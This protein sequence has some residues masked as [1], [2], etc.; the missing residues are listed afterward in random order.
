[1]LSL[2]CFFLC[3]D[4]GRRAQARLPDRRQRPAEDRPRARAPARPFRPRRGRDPQRPELTG[5]AASPPA[6]RSGCSRTDGRL[7][8]V[9]GV[10]DWKARGCKGDRRLSQG[11]RAGDHAR[12][13]RRRAE[14][15]RAAR[16]GGRRRQGRAAALGRPAARPPEVGRRA[17]RAA[18]DEA[19]PEA[20]PGA[21]RARRRRRLRPL[22]GDRQGRDLGRRRAVTAGGRRAARR[23]PRRDDE[24]RAHRRLGRTRR[25]RRA[26]GIRGHCSSARAIRARRRSRA[27]PAILTSH[28]ARIRRAQALEAQGIPAKDAAATLKQHPY[29]VGKLYAQAATTTPTSSVTRR[30]GWRSSTTR[31]RAAPPAAGARARAR[32]DR[33]HPDAP[34][35]NVS[36]RP[37]RRGSPRRC[38]RRTSR[39]RRGSRSVGTSGR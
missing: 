4:R 28:V 14:E 32:A 26:A 2:P 15:G 38:G 30:C 7:I 12:A 22:V 20:L 6:T 37:A 33:D 35:L 39:A 3:F 29:Y 21:A 19:E 11:A 18:R 36:A 8:V 5:D 17:V 13:R 25:R 34:A 9:E 16:Q 10:E 23:R 24:L 31:S 1:M 27:S